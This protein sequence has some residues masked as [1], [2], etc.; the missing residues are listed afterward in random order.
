VKI[1]HV[2]HGYAPAVG[3]TQ[4]MVQNISERLAAE[5]GDTV[6]VFTTVAYS[7]AYFWDRRQPEMQPGVEQI[8]GVTVRRFSVFNRLGWLRLNVARVAHKLRLPSEDWLRGLYFGPLIRGMTRAVAESGADVVMASAFPLMHMHYALWGG[9]RGGIPTVL[10]G[11]LHPADK[12]CFDRPMIYE[13]V[14]RCTA[15]VAYTGF[16]RDYLAQR[17]VD[18]DKV[19]IIGGGVDPD[20]YQRADGPAAR[21]RYG[22]GD[23]PIVAIVA[24]HL[25]HKRI[26]LLIQA[27]PGVWQRFPEAML[28]IVG[29]RTDYSKHLER[30]VRA[31]SPEQQAR[32]VMVS[33]FSDP[34]KADLFAACDVFVLPSS[35][36]AFG[37][38]FAEAWAC[39]KPVIGSRICAVPSVI[40]ENVDGL[41]VRYDDAEDL[42]RAINELLSD[43]GRRARMGQAGREKVLENYTWDIITGRFRDLYCR[44]TQR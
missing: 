41:L 39:G 3:G 14:R 11:A 19:T 1:L 38:V 33:E 9:E 21:R 25:R 36:E 28:L 23:A 10:F 31:Y 40:D 8:N 26:D 2:V 24:Q 42:A 6:T 37:I 18:P 17:G 16:E 20:A 32:I 30:L 29:K 34:E 15:Y 12:W 7:N 22:W 44:V 27:M 13:A 5:Y 43:P 4:W 35:H